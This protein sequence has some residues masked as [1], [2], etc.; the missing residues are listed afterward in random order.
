M[1]CSSCQYND[2]QLLAEETRPIVIWELRFHL[3]SSCFSGHSS[4]FHW[5]GCKIGDTLTF[6]SLFDYLRP[7]FNRKTCTQEG[8]EHHCFFCYCAGFT[9]YG[10]RGYYFFI[11]QKSIGTILE[12]HCC[13]FCITHSSIPLFHLLSSKKRNGFEEVFSR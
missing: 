12:Y 10:Y 11:H 13:G 9:K 8:I 2:G 4:R 5:L 7:Y 6:C 3:R 1:R